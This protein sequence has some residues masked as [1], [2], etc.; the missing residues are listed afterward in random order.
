MHY[1][2]RLEVRAASSRDSK[3]GCAKNAC[4]SL[5]CLTVNLSFDNPFPL[6]V[7]QG[8]TSRAES[9]LQDTYCGLVLSCSSPLYYQMLN[10]DGTEL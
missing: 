5:T 10:N 1:R 7:Y 3:Y 8:S 6:W 9:W 4:D 2:L